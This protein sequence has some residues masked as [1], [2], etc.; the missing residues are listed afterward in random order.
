MLKYDMDQLLR[1]RRTCGFKQKELD[2]FHATC[3]RFQEQGAPDDGSILLSEVLEVLAAL[4]QVPTAESER[5]ELS[6][7]LMRVDRKKCGRLAFEELLLL[8]RHLMS[9]K[10]KAWTDDAKKARAEMGLDKSLEM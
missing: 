1:W 7:A 3:R 9:R 4:D 5:R 6:T 8:L 2:H 10:R